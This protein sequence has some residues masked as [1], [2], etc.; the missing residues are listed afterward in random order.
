MKVNESMSAAAVANALRRATNNPAE[1]E[2]AVVLTA[3]AFFM[4]HYHIPAH[5]ATMMTLSFTQLSQ[6]CRG[7]CPNA[8]WCARVFQAAGYEARVVSGSVKGVDAH[9]WCEIRSGIAD[10]LQTRIQGYDWYRKY[11]DNNHARVC[12][13]SPATQKSPNGCIVKRSVKM[14]IRT[15]GELGP[16]AQSAYVYKVK[17]QTERTLV[18]SVVPDKSPLGN[19]TA[20]APATQSPL[21]MPQTKTSAREVESAARTAPEP[22]AG[23]ERSSKQ[24]TISNKP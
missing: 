23:W 16:P 13:F 7:C 24:V 6:S 4:T 22:K 11:Y 17:T 1:F 2:N 20:P 18:S 5:Y 3:K 21:V 19:A 14:P 12:I 10:V 15:W 8:F 9:F